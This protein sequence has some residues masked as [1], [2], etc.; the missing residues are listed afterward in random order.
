MIY[1]FCHAQT[2]NIS[3][4]ISS[5]FRVLFLQKGLFVVDFY[6]GCVI[7]KVMCHVRHE[8]GNPNI[9]KEKIT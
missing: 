5:E 1:S 8:P 9:R 2:Y 3:P 4:G 6:G 7:M